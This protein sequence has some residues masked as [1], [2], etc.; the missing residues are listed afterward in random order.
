[1]SATL[2]EALNNLEKQIGVM[3]E[4]VK[5]LSGRI[6]AVDPNMIAERA[7]Q[8]ALRGTADLRG[9]AE[10]VS[11][12]ASDIRSTVA[13]FRQS[14]GRELRLRWWFIAIY[15]MVT[16]V[17]VPLV[18]GLGVVTSQK[19][20]AFAKSSETVE[21]ARVAPEATRETEDVEADAPVLGRVLDTVEV[22]LGKVELVELSLVEF[23]GATPRLSF[24]V[25]LKGHVRAVE[26]E[27]RLYGQIVVSSVVRGENEVAIRGDGLAAQLD[28]EKPVLEAGSEVRLDGDMAAAL[29]A[30]KELH[31][32]GE[33]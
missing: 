27:G 25:M 17:V 4:Q 32:A 28:L 23:V 19:V 12:A 3:G 18:Y 6:Q 7:E 29:A 8:G 11:G 1:M 22:P 30:I 15:A 2:I 20:V 10:K 5:V 24:G 9:Q 16:L 26:H 13:E 31:T 21:S 14:A 33:G